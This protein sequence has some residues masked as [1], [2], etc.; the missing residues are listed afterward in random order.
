MKTLLIVCAAVALTLFLS[1]PTPAQTRTVAITVDD[2][3]YAGPFLNLPNYSS[4]EIN[5]RLLAAF[6]KHHIPVT[7]F[8]IQKSVEQKPDLA[9][10]TRVLQH[11]I[12]SGLDLANHTYSHS[13]SNALTIDQIKQEII[14]GEK[15][16][17][18]LMKS[19]GKQ[20]EFFRFPMNHT[21]DTKEKHDAIAAFLVQHGYQLATCTIDNSD[22]IFNVAYVKMLQNNDAASAQRLRAEYIAYTSTEIDYYSALNKQIFSYEPPHVMLLHD[23][24]L[25]SDTIDDVLKLFESRNYKFVTLKTAQSDPAYQTPETFFTQYGWMWGYRWANELN[26]KVNG[27]LETEPPQWI[28]DYGKEDLPKTVPSTPKT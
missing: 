3:P 8:V 22:F 23:N 13:D 1:A 24:P 25:N 12:A 4:D 21:G 15:T 26:V 28:L 2:L 6:A 9:T 27:S 19:A 20:P 5:N 14:D 17:V 11:W 16:F 7:G 18:P 10:G